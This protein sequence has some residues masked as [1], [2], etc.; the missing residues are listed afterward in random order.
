[1]RE[2]RLFKIVYHLLEKGQ[3]TAPE[4]AELLEVSVRTVYRD[5]D[6]LSAAGIPIYAQTGRNGGICLKSD[7]VL[8]KAFLSHAEKQDILAS[9]QSVNAL[10][11]MELDET[12]NKLSALFQLNANRWLEVD[13][14]RWGAQSSDNHKF[15]LLKT[16][17]LEQSAVKITYASSYEI[18]DERVIY[19]LCLSYR[20]KAWYVKAYCTKKQAYRLFKLNRILACEMMTEHFTDFTYP[21]ETYDSDQMT[22]EVMLRFPKEAAYRVYDEFDQSQIE[23]LE[24]KDLLV[25]AAMPIDQWL[26]G[27]LLSFGTAVEIVSPPELKEMTANQAHLIYEKNK[28]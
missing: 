8:D 2:S 19:P 11:G 21:S 3:T 4:L 10:Q 28:L 6:S 12:F 18:I 16:A 26:I 14:S 22:A 17:V 27:Y 25:S 23:I 20:A 13:F 7:F 9:L 15:Q 5:L 24:N 1:M